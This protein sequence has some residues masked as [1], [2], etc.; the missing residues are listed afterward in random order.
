MGFGLVWTGL[1]GLD[2]VWT[3]PL[4]ASLRSRGRISI[5]KPTRSQPEGRELLRTAQRRALRGHPLCLRGYERSK[6]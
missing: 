2:L 1:D 6:L 3:M 5:S 4:R